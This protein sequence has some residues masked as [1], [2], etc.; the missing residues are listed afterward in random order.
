MSK[1]YFKLSDKWL[2]TRRRLR[3]RTTSPHKLEDVNDFSEFIAELLG[4][5]SIL[6]ERLHKLEVM[7]K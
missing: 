6:E 1:N 2:E 5:Y 7:K 4:Y 3:G